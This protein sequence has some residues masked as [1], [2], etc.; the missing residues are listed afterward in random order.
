MTTNRFAVLMCWTF[1]ACGPPLTPEMQ[2]INDAAEAM[3]GADTIAETET[4]LLEGEGRQYRL[5][6]NFD[7]DDPL[8]YWELDT[9][10]RE[11][12]LA[13][14]QW[15]VI[16]TRTP[17]YLM[18]GNP[19]LREE[20][21]LGIDGDTAYTISEDGTVRRDTA[22]TARD[23][24]LDHYHHPVTLLRLALAEG[25]TVGNL[26]QEDGE[27]VVDITSAAGESYTMYVD[28]ATKHPSRIVSTGSNTT[29]GDVTLTTRFE[30]YWET[31]G[32]GGFGARLTMPRTIVA[33]T[34]EFTTWELRVE[35]N[36]DRDLGDLGAPEEAR[37]AVPPAFRADVQVEEVGNGVWRLAGQSHHSLL[38]EFDEFLVL[39]EAPQHD[40]RTLAVI[41][42]ARELNP[43]K[44]LRYLVNTHHH[45]DHSGGIRAAV[46]EGLTVIT[47]ESNAVF[48]EDMVGRP[49]TLQPDALARAPRELT[50]ELVTNDVYDV[51]DG[52]RTM[53]IA[54]VRQ[55]EHAK[56][57]LMAYLP[58]ER[59]LV[60][61]D[62]YTP[63]ARLVPFA[64]NLLEAI[65]RLGWRVDRIVPLHGDVV[66]MSMLEGAI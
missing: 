23:R 2:L 37:S 42:K 11:I 31:G 17:M 7:P 66:E 35:A 62:A 25:S 10:R 60:E 61:A 49:H 56:G 20:Q 18:T 15:R 53:H 55:D 8:P 22:Q 5:G 14:D 59:I 44:P 58:R 28:P 33:A 51:S 43:D 45:F 27:D 57:M 6:Q 13:N 4:L 39:V 54:R 40:A 32:V 63:N 9:Y 12:D 50:L 1:V 36:A 30:D 34:E 64:G 26:R 19:V 65:N 48:Y 24:Y 21:T 41:E 38:V 46:S 47:H 3:G 16:L 52:H 29:L